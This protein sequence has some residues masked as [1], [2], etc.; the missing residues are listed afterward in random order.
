MLVLG[1]I[2]N[3]F[4]TCVSMFRQL[5]SAFRDERWKEY[6]GHQEC[7][8]ATCVVQYVLQAHSCQQSQQYP[9]MPWWLQQVSCSVLEL[10]QDTVLSLLDSG[11][12]SKQEFKVF[13][14]FEWWN[15]T[16]R[17]SHESLIQAFTCIWRTSFRGI[18]LMWGTVH[19]CEGVCPKL[20]IWFWVAR[21][22]TFIK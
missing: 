7:L 15:L 21:C 18:L 1:D 9:K 4:W 8:V 22:F 10:E 13:V 19:S 12:W 3:H 14:K 16:Q 2:P 17:K 20:T 6:F 11:R 5:N